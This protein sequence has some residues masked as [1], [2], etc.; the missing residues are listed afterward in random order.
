MTYDITI[1]KQEKTDEIREG[2]PKLSALVGAMTTHEVMI[3]SDGVVKKKNL[4]TDAFY[5]AVNIR[6]SRKPTKQVEAIANEN[7]NLD[8][9]FIE[10]DSQRDVT[11]RRIMTNALCI[12]AE[13]ENSSDNSDIE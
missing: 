5:K 4:P 3:T 11:S 2:L 1:H 8:D 9:A 10:D 12:A 13:L 6:E 7:N